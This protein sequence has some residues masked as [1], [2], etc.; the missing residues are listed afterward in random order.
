MSLLQSLARLS[1]RVSMWFHV[2]QTAITLLDGKRATNVA[3]AIAR[4]KHS[5]EVIAEKVLVDF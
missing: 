5:Y 1:D 4:I 2:M 3:I